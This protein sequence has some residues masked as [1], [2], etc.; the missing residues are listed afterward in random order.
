LFGL[1]GQQIAWDHKHVTETRIRDLPFRYKQYSA[2]SFQAGNKFLDAKFE[3]GV[4]TNG[5]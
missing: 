1:P 4:K 2:V 5:N 3:N